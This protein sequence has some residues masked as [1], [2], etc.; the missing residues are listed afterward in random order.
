MDCTQWW[1]PHW[2]GFWI[3]P[4]LFMILMFVFAARMFRRAG[5]WRWCLGN[6]TRWKPLDGGKPGQ[7]SSEGW[8]SET[9]CQILDRRYANGEITKEQYE[10]MKRDIG[11][12]PSRHRTAAGAM[13][14]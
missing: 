4:L 13:A 8:W 10:Q 14:S 3:I 1:E 11:P 9:P 12:N 6:C 5:D 2:H 7:D